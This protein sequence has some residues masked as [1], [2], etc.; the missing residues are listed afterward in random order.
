MSDALALFQRAAEVAGAYRS[1]VTDLPVTARATTD[2]LREAFALP[3]PTSP[4]PADQVLEELVAAAEPGLVHTA[5]GRFFGFV[6][7][8]SYDLAVAA[9]MVTAGWDQ[10]AYN[11]VLTP[12]GAMAEQV[13]GGWLKE[14]LGLP[15]TASVGF[16]TGGQEANTVGLASGRHH[17]LAEAGWDVEV[18]GMTGAPRVRIVAG[19]ERH[20]TIDRALRLLGFGTNALEPVDVDA[21]GAI[22]PDALAATLASQPPGPTIVCLQAGNVN[23][24][25]CDPLREAIGV[26]HDRGAWVH[27]DGAFG[28]WAAASPTTRPL[29]DGIE[30]ADSWGCDGHKWLNLTYDSGFAICS[31]P[32]VHAAAVR[33]SAAYLTG[34]GGA[35]LGMSDF[36]L[37]SSRRAKGFA[38]WALLRHLGRDGVAALV[39]HLC[40]MARRFAGGLAGGGSRIANDVVLNMVLADF[41][42]DDTNRAIAAAV[43]AEG[44]CWLATTEWQGRTLLRMSLSSCA[45]TEADVDASVASVLRQA[46]AAAR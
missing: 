25:A 30:L 33:Y 1:S 23:T 20:A 11:G 28:L 5:G 27:V 16:V 3:L 26:A 22:R 34:S 8:G 13:A 9:E 37:E 21:N 46:A 45:T 43:Q 39:D 10:C 44:T 24:G 2:E 42:D 41:G 18:E 38:T 17:V 36:T 40:A 35:D 14:L 15:A 7:G 32:E 31:R 4:L 12:A 6:I 29:V 19:A